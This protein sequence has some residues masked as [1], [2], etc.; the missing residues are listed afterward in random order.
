MD[1]ED[2]LD[3]LALYEIDWRVQA[4]NAYEQAEE[5]KRNAKKGRRKRG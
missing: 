4:I 1:K 5:T 2:R 3:T